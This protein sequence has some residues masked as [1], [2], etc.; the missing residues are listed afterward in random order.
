MN[1]F[2][3][4]NRCQFIALLLFSTLSFALGFSLSYQQD[5]NQVGEIGRLASAHL[6]YAEELKDDMA[7]IDWSK[8]L[9]KLNGLRSFQVK[10]N[11]K[12]TAE[13]GN[14]DFLAHPVAEGIGYEFPSTWSYRA[15]SNADPQNVKEFIL[16]YNLWPGPFLLGLFYF[17]G[18]FLGGA[19]VMALQT[20]N[21]KIIRPKVSIVPSQNNFTVSLKTPTSSADP[22]PAPVIPIETPNNGKPFLLVD[23]ALII[24]EASTQAAELLG[25]NLN[26]LSKI[27]LIDLK[28]H[29]LLVQ[30][31]ENAE[32]GKFLNPFAEHPHL[33]AFVKRDIKGC[34]IFLESRS[35]TSNP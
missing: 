15:T 24:L 6:S 32:E 34:L 1:P 31:V 27:H 21:S 26:L 12:V 14:Q 33:I 11:S 9:E 17:G 30:A 29:P 4:F 10:V 2:P 3:P 23:N 16:I 19:I 5:G 13:G 7:V 25:A 22:L 8:N 35:E 28:P 20:K 18:A